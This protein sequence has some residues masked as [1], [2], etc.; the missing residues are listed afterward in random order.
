[1]INIMEYFDYCVNV[2]K[3]S[4]NEEDYIQ[5][6]NLFDSNSNIDDIENTYEYIYQ[7]KNKFYKY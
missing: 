2:I 6:I 5:L 4:K 3:L 1:M 7:L